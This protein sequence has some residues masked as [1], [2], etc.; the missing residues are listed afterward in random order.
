M[1]R[2]RG[3]SIGLSLGFLWVVGVSWNGGWLDFFSYVDYDGGYARRGGCGFEL[4]ACLLALGSNSRVTMGM[5]RVKLV[6]LVVLG[7]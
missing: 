2:M 3:R 1:L 5:Y 6:V 4:H 7:E